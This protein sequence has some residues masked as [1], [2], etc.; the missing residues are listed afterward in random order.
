M[1]AMGG[2]EY[3]LGRWRVLPELNE[4]RSDGVTRRL[5][6][7]SMDVLVALLAKEGGVV[8]KEEILSEVWPE[9]F[10]S[11][12][13][14]FRVISELRRALGDDRQRP[15]FIQTVPKRGYRIVA[16]PAP[17]PAETGGDS[18]STGDGP[19]R[20]RRLRWRWATVPA[21]LVAAIVLTQRLQR[22]DGEPAAAPP[23]LEAVEASAEGEVWESRVS[24]RA[25]ARA[26]SAYHQALAREP[27]LEDAGIGLIDSYLASSVLGCVSPD[28]SR[29][30]LSEWIG[31][32]S[33]WRGEPW[34]SAKRGAFS[35]WHDWDPAAAAAHFESG[36]RETGAADPSRAAL[37]LI[38][39][40]M[41]EGVAEARRVRQQAPAALGENWTLGAAL[42]LGRRYHEA[43][44]QFERTLALHEGFPPAETQRAL[45][46]LRAGDRMRG[47]ALAREAAAH[48]RAPLDRFSSLPALVFAEAGARTER[49]TFVDAWTGEASRQ[50]WVAPTARA[51]LAIACD[52]LSEANDWLEEGYR[53]RDPWLVLVRVDPAFD[54][55]R[56]DARFQALVARIHR[57]LGG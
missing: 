55:L 38:L 12:G 28:E 45:A 16:G 23:D 29:P 48:L 19:Y 43:A 39:G 57:Q 31:K 41:E 8:T 25:Y 7:K 4:L 5:E 40:R 30:P 18:R 1:A 46:V 44:E 47:L 6:P 42:L 21:L 54:R 15:L 56:V 52:R 2:R 26:R 11:D 3:S 34:L 53:V 14:L 24:C 49:T 13:A 36:S 35:L 20:P 27:T 33:P 51:V 10:V 22:S 17:S 9:T 50:T 37:A 32:G